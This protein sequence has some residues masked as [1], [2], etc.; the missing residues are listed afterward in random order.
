MKKVL[1]M[2]MLCPLLFVACKK[3]GGYIEDDPIVKTFV[4]NKDFTYI[5][6]PSGSRITLDA[7][8]PGATSYLW[9]QAGETSPSI[10][11]DGQHN[12]IIVEI[13][14]SGSNFL[15]DIFIMYDQTRINTPTS[16]TPNGDGK[17]DFWM[18]YLYGVEEDGFRLSIFN[19]DLML[20][21]STDTVFN[22]RW[23][24][25]Y[26][27]VVQPVGTY[28]FTMVYNNNQYKPCSASGQFLLLK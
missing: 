9:S 27:E 24:G 6:V 21:F 26:K 5:I 23:D 11:W 16:F 20:L 2:L 28:Y 19:S 3:Y 18:P 15:Y 4:I 7:T 22:P 12:G 1:L 17:N 10:V 25:R 13:T 8:M 14:A